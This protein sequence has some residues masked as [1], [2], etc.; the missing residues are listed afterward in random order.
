MDMAAITCGEL[1]NMSADDGGAVMLWVHGYFGGMADD[2]KFDFNAFKK[3]AKAIG[4]YCGEDPKVTLISAI[5][6]S[7]TEGLDRRST[8]CCA[9]PLPRRFV[10]GTKG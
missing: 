8:P 3:A 1:L 6:S 7:R 10:P 9:A 2:T 4:A 5:K